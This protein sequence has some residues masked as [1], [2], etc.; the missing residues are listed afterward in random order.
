MS[1]ERLVESSKLNGARKTALIFSLVLC[2]CVL[3]TSALADPSWTPVLKING[4]FSQMYVPQCMST[5]LYTPL[6]E[7]QKTF[8]VGQNIN[9]AIDPS[10]LGLYHM[11]FTINTGDGHTY[12]ANHLAHEFSKPGSYIVAVH[13]SEQL[14]AEDSRGNLD[15]VL[16]NIL[17]AEK[18]RRPKPQ[19]LIDGKKFARNDDDPYNFGTGQAL[20]FD[21]SQSLPGTS[22]IKKFQWDFGDNTESNDITVAHTYA[23]DA[24]FLIVVLRATDQNGLFADTYAIVQNDQPGIALKNTLS[25]AR[26]SKQSGI[27]KRFYDFYSNLNVW[28]R[29]RLAGSGAQGQ[30]IPLK[31]LLVTL[32]I[33]VFLGSLHS[34]TPGHSKS[35][36]AAILIAKK[37]TQTK[38]VLALAAA[39]TITHTAVIYL[40]GVFFL[41]LDK[42]ASLN[43]IMPYFTFVNKLLVVGLGFWLFSRGVRAWLH[44][45]R[46]LHHQ[47]GEETVTEHTHDHSHPHD[48]AHGHDHAHPHAHAEGSDV[49]NMIFAG[50]SGGLVPC[51][52]ALSILIL[53][54]S[55][56]MVGL[57]LLIILFF[58]LG[59]AAS[60]VVLG[61]VVIRTKKL[62]KLEDRIG[63]RISI[64]APLLTGLVVII[65][66]FIFLFS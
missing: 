43:R 65:L 24:D 53:S 52:D 45:R 22:A 23:A 39:I 46:H 34:L 33:A 21:A 10:E 29:Q 57:G 54:A 11:A 38:D 35:I 19:I 2:A 5:K 3:R 15:S 32:L 40:L 8:L 63:E 26:T 37:E 12:K 31:F 41:V 27:V 55:L 25:A 42:T 6:G 4:E 9:F 7:C 30:G 44:R 56:H 28:F 50:A 61:M 51:L 13:A 49:W 48:H 47:A 62:I 66:G 36:M 20:Q 60:I 16:V 1:G 59:L 14:G 58:S 64:F 17:P 18:Y